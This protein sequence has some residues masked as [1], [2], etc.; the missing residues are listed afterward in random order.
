MLKKINF[1]LRAIKR[2]YFLSVLLI[3]LKSSGGLIFS[4][5]L[6]S[7]VGSDYHVDIMRDISIVLGLSIIIKFG[8]DSALIKLTTQFYQDKNRTA[9][10]KLTVITLIFCALNSTFIYYA[11]DFFD[12]YILFRTTSLNVSIFAG[13]SVSI[14]L[15]L[16][17]ML[18]AIRLVNMSFFGETGIIMLVSLPVIVNFFS[19]D[20]TI[21]VFAIVWCVISI[22]SLF[23]LFIRFYKVKSSS[24]KTSYSYLFYTLIVLLPSLFINSLINYIQQWGVIFLATQNLAQVNASSFILVIRITY[25]FNAVLS[26]LSSYVVPEVIRIY[27]KSGVRD[28]N[29]FILKTKSIFIYS[30]TI[31]LL[32]SF[33]ATA[34][35]FYPEF[36]DFLFLSS[37]FIFLVCSSMNLFSGP[38]NMYMALLG[39]E[40]QLV[41]LRLK[42]AIP[43]IIILFFSSGS[44]FVF[45][46]AMY[47]LLQRT[48]I[49][50]SL[51]KE[52]GIVSI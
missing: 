17:S 11:L 43:S 44:F 41:E 25:I 35:V 26:P 31:C 13:F 16:M 42:I 46:V 47:V 36:D 18:K 34:Y 49:I 3:G 39:F 23:V 48:F 33:I 8:L 1:K 37:I 27:N 15:C 9:L 22:L 50:Y 21:L 14:C 45:S 4:W 38:L 6:V 19:F 12:G 5:F 51:K 7:F 24:V 2:E 30:G 29:D 52:A 10:L 28:V 40:R 32:I 20:E